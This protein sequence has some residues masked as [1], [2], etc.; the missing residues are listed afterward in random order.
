MSDDDAPTE[1]GVVAAAMR[2]E[3]EASCRLDG[4]TQSIPVPPDDKSTWMTSHDVAM[5]LNR[6]RNNDV[7]VSIDG[8]LVPVA[9]VQY[10]RFADVM[11][12]ELVDGQDLR[13]ALAGYE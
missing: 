9:N 4:E 7:K 5:A 10:D 1:A 3:A 6:C 11:V 13:I 2:S 8:C 12:I